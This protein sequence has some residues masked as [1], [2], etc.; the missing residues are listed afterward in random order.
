MRDTK[1]GVVNAFYDLVAKFQLSN[2]AR[3]Y[4]GGILEPDS[5]CNPYLAFAAMLAAGTDGIEKEIDCGAPVDKNIFEMSQREKSRLKIKQLPVDLNEAVVLMNKSNFIQE[6]LGEHIFNQFITT[7]G[8]TW[9]EYIS[10]VHQWE[11]ER[12]L[13]SY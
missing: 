8:K 11:I 3:N 10:T 7:K 2:I 13:T 5:S 1:D 4:I 9:S 6:T 12:Y